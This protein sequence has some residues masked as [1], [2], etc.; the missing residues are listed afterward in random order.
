[1]RNIDINLLP[2]A[3]IV[4][5]RLVAGNANSRERQDSFDMAL[6]PD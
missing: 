2:P 4:K 1:M 6:R 5:I 3:V